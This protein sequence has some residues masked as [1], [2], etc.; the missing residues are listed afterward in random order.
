MAA[1]GVNGLPMYP[2]PQMC[3]ALYSAN[4]AVLPHF[5]SHLCPKP[6]PA[7]LGARRPNLALWQRVFQ[8]SKPRHMAHLPPVPRS[9]LRW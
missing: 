6:R 4:L 7:H 3:H 2:T 1:T 5:T 8:C 9:H